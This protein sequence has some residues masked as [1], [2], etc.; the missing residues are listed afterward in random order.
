[1][2][3]SAAAADA[4]VEE[5][6]ELVADRLGDR[7]QGVERGDR[8]V[9]LAAAVVGDDDPVDAALRRLAG[10]VDVLDPLD[11]DRQRGPLAQPGEVVPVQRGVGLDAEEVAGGSADVLLRRSSPAPAR[12]T[13]SWK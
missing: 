10:V 6:R 2:R 1:M 3:T 5:D 13:G 9:D 11:E 8:A 12:K 4:A 7:R